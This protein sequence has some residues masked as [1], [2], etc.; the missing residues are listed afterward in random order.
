MEQIWNGAGKLTL[1]EYLYL[2]EFVHKRWSWCMPCRVVL[3]GIQVLF[4]FAPLKLET[5]CDKMSLESGAAVSL[6]NLSAR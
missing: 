1:N 3:P 6:P 5:F 2:M 4:F